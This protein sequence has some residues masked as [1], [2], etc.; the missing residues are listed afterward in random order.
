MFVAKIR[1]CGHK[2]VLSS[3]GG[4]G[5]GTPTQVTAMVEGHFWV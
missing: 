1:E 4:G 5:G 3:R 2:D